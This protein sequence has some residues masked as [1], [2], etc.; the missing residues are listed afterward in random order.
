[1]VGRVSTRCTS[2]CPVLYLFYDWD[3]LAP[4]APSRV[5]DE[6][7]WIP[8]GSLQVRRVPAALRSSRR[9]QDYVATAELRGG[10]L[11]AHLRVQRAR[12]DL[13]TGA[14]IARRWELT[15]RTL[16]ER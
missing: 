6:G 11:S 3:W 14:A 5:L 7:G 9:P 12:V 15:L 1:E 8:M 10:R 2:L 16:A 13:E 4:G